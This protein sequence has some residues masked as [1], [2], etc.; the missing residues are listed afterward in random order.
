MHLFL[1]WNYGLLC[2]FFFFSRSWQFKYLL[3]WKAICCIHL[4]LDCLSCQLEAIFW[5]YCD[6]GYLLFSSP[7]VLLFLSAESQALCCLTLEHIIDLLLKSLFL[8][9]FMIKINTYISWNHIVVY[10]S[11]LWPSKLVVWI[12]M[13][14]ENDLILWYTLA[15]HYFGHL[16]WYLV[17]FLIYL[18]FNWLIHISWSLLPRVQ[19]LLWN[20]QYVAPALTS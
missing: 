17:Y 10:Y 9:C 18:M 13:N 15:F 20:I 7:F 1:F 14:L 8:V 19:Q 4:V 12:C 2:F 5:K 16:A 11:L 3:T 6:L